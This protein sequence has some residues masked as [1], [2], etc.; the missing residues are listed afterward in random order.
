LEQE[1]DRKG[2]LVTR[3]RDRVSEHDENVRVVREE[4]ARK[5]PER[6][7]LSGPENVCIRIRRMHA[8]TFCEVRA[9]I[10]GF[11]EE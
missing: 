6:D 4:A 8:G 2:L 10:G 9:E 3:T 1:G 5:T 11:D 7:D